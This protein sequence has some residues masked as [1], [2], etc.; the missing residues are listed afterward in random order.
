MAL[1]ADQVIERARLF[2]PAIPLSTDSS[3]NGLD[4]LNEALSELLFD[5]EMLSAE[6]D[7][8]LTAGTAHYSLPSGTVRLWSARYVRSATT[9]DFKELRPTNQDKL[10]NEGLGY[11]RLGSSEPDK[12]WALPKSDGTPEIWVTPSPP[13]TTSSGYPKIVVRVTQYTALSTG[14][15]SLPLGLPSYDVFIT[16]LAEKWAFLVGDEK[17]TI[18][19]KLHQEKKAMA[20]NFRHSVAARVHPTMRP[21]V[22]WRP[23]KV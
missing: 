1:T 20:H 23:R 3:P 7:L 8:T 10:D 22:S 13:T 9:G 5:V 4:L 11:L 14:S 12:Y 16:A 15:S 6:S 17:I 18:I 19:E 2:F 21:R